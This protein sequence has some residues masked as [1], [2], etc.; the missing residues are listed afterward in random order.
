MYNAD[1]II[2]YGSEGVCKIDKIDKMNISGI[3]N[4][5]MY[6]YLTPL[7][8]GGTIYAPTDTPV[9]MRYVISKDEALKLI[10]R[11]PEIP[12]DICK[13]NNVRILNEHYQE[14]IKSCDCENLVKIIK[15]IETKKASALSKGKR[16]GSVDEKYLNKA[17]DMLLGELAVSLETDKENVDRYIRETVES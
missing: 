1:D 5:R 8:H 4:D 13:E 7:Y 16:L 10:E 17:R 2:I 15:S 9:K 14:L 6:Y 11:I 3:K 12:A